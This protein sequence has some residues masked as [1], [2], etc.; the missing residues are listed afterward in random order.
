VLL[1]LMWGGF[2]M[3]VAGLAISLEPYLPRSRLR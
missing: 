1:P 2:A 3:L